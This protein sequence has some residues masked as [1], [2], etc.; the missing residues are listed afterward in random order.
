MPV[1]EKYYTVE[2]VA[3]EL[4]VAPE[5]VLRYIKRKQLPALK[6]GGVYRI[7]ADDYEHFKATRRTTSEKESNSSQ[8]S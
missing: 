3:K 1:M 8:E 4:R 5:T 2:E 6:V 7:L